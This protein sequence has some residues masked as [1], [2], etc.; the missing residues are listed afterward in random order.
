MFMTPDRYRKL[1]GEYDALIFHARAISDRL[2]GRTLERKFH[3]YSDA[4]YTKLI[5]HGIS[6]R[7]LSPSLDPEQATELWD[8]ASGCAV[9]R[10]LIEAYD[11]LAYIGVHQVAPEEREFRM[12]LW[13]LHDQQR[14]L[15][16]LNKIGSVDPRVAEINE[17]VVELS[18]K[19][20][21]NAVYSKVSK[22]IRGKVAR[23]EAPP[24]HLSQRDL[25]AASGINHEYYIA[26][27]MF[28][29]QYVHTYPLSLHQ[30]MHFR[31]GEPGALHLSSM[32]LQ[33]SMPFLAKAIEGMVG[34]FPEG[35][36]EP[37]GEVSRVL[38]SW[39]VIA[40]NGVTYA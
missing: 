4:I 27:T 8:L 22:E 25:N 28:L 16:M 40:E 21:A 39:L 6:L 30:L 1:L 12:L 2:V 26:A 7:K 35:K 38:R 32:P 19:L 14:R 11:A 37:S 9:A 34:I 5:C 24:I 23:G 3:S 29:S 20:T 13:E 18:A 36:V 15:T 31:A 10:A 17:R 33:Y